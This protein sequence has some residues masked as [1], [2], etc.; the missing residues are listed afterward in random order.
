M[1][2]APKNACLIYVFGDADGRNAKFGKTRNLAELRMQQHQTRG[3]TK[4]EMVP[5]AVM[6]G[7]DSDERTLREKWKNIRIGDTLEWVDPSNEKFRSWLRFLRQQACVATSFDEI[8]KLPYVDSRYWLPG[9]KNSLEF[10]QC[11]FSFSNDPWHDLNSD[12]E[13][14]GDYYTNRIVIDAARHAMGSIDLDP[15]SC[16]LAN[17]VV[18]APRFFG[19]L[20]DG[21]S[22]QWNGRIWL[23]PPF[24]QWDL[25]VPKLLSEIQSGRVSQACVL[26]PARASTAKQFHQIVSRCDAIF[27]PN[28]RIP[29]WGPKA[30]TPDEGHF[31]FYIGN[32]VNNFCNAF[33]GIGT[34]FISQHTQTMSIE[35]AE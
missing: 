32:Q 21:L 26:S 23:N 28:G 7:H 13:G 20:Q 9:G 6:W 27:F 22:E 10:R 11:R 35:A 29:F 8:E 24:G 34:V 25:W 3:P 16:R 15:A 17:T 1:G 4:I 14:D 30:G 31:I 2:G 19:A 33:G 18:R 12:E 5:L